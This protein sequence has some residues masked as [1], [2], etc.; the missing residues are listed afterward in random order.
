M[1][2][3]R[4]RKLTGRRK[5]PSSTADAGR[6]AWVLLLQ[7]LR[8]QQGPMLAVWA[9]FGVSSSQGELLCSLEPKQ[10]A[11]MVSLAKTL[12]C[13]DSNVTGLVDKLEQRGLIERCGD[14]KDRRVKLIVL[15]ADGER[16]R[17]KLLERI[18]EPLPFI[19]GLSVADKKALRDILR[20]AEERGRASIPRTEIG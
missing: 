7:M 20:R 17:E 12:H 16:L 14:P 11:P 18:Y 19:Q 4:K 9:E 1:S 6:E 2:A 15:T 8:A 3:H 5:R 13:H 10:R